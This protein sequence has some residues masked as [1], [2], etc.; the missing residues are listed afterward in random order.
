MVARDFEHPVDANENNFYNLII[1]AST[2]GGS[3]ATDEFTV[4]VNNVCEDVVGP[5]NKLRATDPIGDVNGDTA[6]LEITIT[7]N[8][9][10]PRSGVAVTL[11]QESGAATTFTSSGTTNASGVFTTTVSS[12]IVGDASFS[13]RYESVTGS[14]VDTDIEMGNPTSVRFLPDIADRDSKGDVGINTNTPHPSSILEVAA[15]DRGLLIPQVALTGCSDTSTIPNPSV[16]LLVFNTNSSSSLD[17]GFVWFDGEEW[18]SI[19]NAEKQE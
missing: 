19:C 9:D 2:P 14:G 12:T 13:A 17:I 5:A 16:S 8:S 11:T 6:T 1:T 15:T 7:D 18:R 4:I 10:V 3:S